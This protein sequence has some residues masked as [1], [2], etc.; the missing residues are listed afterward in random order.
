MSASGFDQY[1][2]LINSSF[3]DRVLAISPKQLKAGPRR[4]GVAGGREKLTLE[5]SRWLDQHFDH[6]PEYRSR[7]LHRGGVFARATVYWRNFIV[8]RGFMPVRPGGWRPTIRR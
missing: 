2:N 8:L 1:G 7:T 4:I 5:L 6:R 3:N